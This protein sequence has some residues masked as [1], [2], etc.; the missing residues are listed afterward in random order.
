LKPTVT[1]LLSDRR[2]GSTVFEQELCAH[3]AICHVDFTP[4]AYN[5][6][7]YWLKAVCALDTPADQFANGL[8]PETYGTKEAV[9]DSLAETIL[10]NAPAFRLD[11]PTHWV[12]QG[13]EALCR[14]FARPVFFE[15]SPQHPQHWAALALMLEWIRATDFEVRVIGLVR[16]PMAVIYSAARRFKTDPGKRQHAWMKTNHH[17]IR[18]GAA[19]E[20]GQFYYLRYEDLVIEPAIVFESVCGFIGVKPL[21]TMGSTVSDEPQHRWRQDPE[22]GFELSRDVGQFAQKLGYSQSEL[23]R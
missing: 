20:P 23:S 8:R 18:F 10:R 11:G 14:Q 21:T 15:K 6:T 17:I 13:W 22:F 4:H 9:R 16:N 19:L 2:S 3:P 7:H 1:I 12:N 5:E